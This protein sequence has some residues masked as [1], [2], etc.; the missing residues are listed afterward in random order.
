MD[1]Q[2]HT[3]VLP[4]KKKEQKQY[5]KQE[6]GE[7]RNSGTRSSP[8]TLHQLERIRKVVCIPGPPLGPPLEEKKGYYCWGRERVPRPMEVKQE[9]DRGDQI[10]NRG[11]S[12][13]IFPNLSSNSNNYPNL[14]TGQ[15]YPVHLTPEASDAPGCTVLRATH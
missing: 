7:S 12:A 1:G 8:V 13:C 2:G 10:V 4:P 3:R 15:P 5:L 9:W 6:K 14:C 11:P